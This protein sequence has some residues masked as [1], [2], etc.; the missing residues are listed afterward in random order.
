LAAEENAHK[1]GKE[2]YYHNFPANRPATEKGSG[3]NK[4]VPHEQDRQTRH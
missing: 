4:Q 2:G 3:S 1:F